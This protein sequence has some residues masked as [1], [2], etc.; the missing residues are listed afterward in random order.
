MPDSNV[1]PYYIRAPRV[2]PETV[3]PEWQD[4]YSWIAQKLLNSRN[5]RVRQQTGSIYVTPDQMKSEP[6]AIWNLLE[7]PPNIEN[8]PN[9]VII[10]LSTNPY[11]L[12]RD[13]FLHHVADLG[14]SW[15]DSARGR[16]LVI[17]LPLL[18][19]S[20]SIFW[21]PITSDDTDFHGQHRLIVLGNDGS[22]WPEEFGKGVLAEYSRHRVV[23]DQDLKKMLDARIVRKL[24]HFPLGSDED[25]H[26]VEYFFETDA[27]EYEIGELVIQW[28]EEYIRPNAIDK[29]FTIV[30]Y[31]NRS[32]RF[33]AAVA[34][35]AAAA[36]CR[37]AAINDR[38]PWPTAG[39][40]EGN[41]ALVLNVVHTGR[42]FRMVTEHLQFQ[43]MGLAPEALAVLTTGPPLSICD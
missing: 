8:K 24:G 12:L 2:A 35:A 15:L 4:L 36:N 20:S 28:I 37:F 41:V 19:P 42:T 10:D 17:L 7:R 16:M 38:D 23:P 22:S 14:R 13:I 21:T 18:P 27:A 39:M 26:C 6:G 34:G 11:H 25:P 3:R 30:S 5:I 32:E 43:G 33:H 1:F 40:I 9:M 31:G 29:E